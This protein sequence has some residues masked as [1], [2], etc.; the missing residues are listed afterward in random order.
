MGNKNRYRG[1]VPDDLREDAIDRDGHTCQMCGGFAFE[2]VG[3]VAQQL[4]IHHIDG[5]GNN[6]VLENVQVVCRKCHL[7]HHRSERAKEN[8]AY[9]ARKAWRDAVDRLMI[10][11]LE[12]R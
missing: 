4:Q 3:P 6:N 10:D 11:G 8:P 2:G 5:D 1:N 9:A 7:E 12:T